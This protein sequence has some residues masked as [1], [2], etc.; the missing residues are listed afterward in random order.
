MNGVDLAAAH[1]TFVHESISAENRF[2]DELLLH[3]PDRRAR[4][5]REFYEQYGESRP[6]G[7]YDWGRQHEEA[8]TAFYRK[9]IEANGHDARS[10]GV[11]IG[12]QGGAGRARG[13]AGQR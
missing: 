13:G 12:C 4:L 5:I 6:T 10:L 11:D 1:G 2:P 3:E 7:Y 9:S 8:K